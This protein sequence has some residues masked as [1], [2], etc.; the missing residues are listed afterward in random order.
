MKTFSLQERYSYP[1]RVIESIKNANAGIQ[2]L[3][4]VIL[5]LVILA[6]PGLSKAT[7]SFARQ[8][9]MSCTAC[10]YSFPE[11]TPFGRQF[12]LNAYTMTMMN[13]ID[14][15]QDSDKVTRLK[16]L[17]YLPLSAM[18]QTSFTNNAKTIEGTQNNS[19]AF[20][21]QISMFYA[22]QITPHIGSFIQMTYDGQV[23][24]MDN[25]EIRYA[26]Q[27]SLGTTSLLYGV[28][29]NNNPTVQDVWNTTPAW[30][31]P[32]A[33]SEAANSPAKA[34]LI[35]SLGMQV[36]GLGVYALFNNLLYGEFTLYRSSPQGAANPPD[37]TSV[38][39]VKGV[40]PYWRVAL[41]HV[42]GNNY[43]ELG[44]FGMNSNN[45]VSGISGP[46][47]KF[48]DLGF[49]LQYEN[50]LNTG[51]FV[52]HSSMIRETE[53]RNSSTTNFH[54]NSFK[55][56]GN[57]YLKNGL[58]ATLG[59]FNSSGTADADVVESSTNKPNSNG[60]IYQI[61]YLP[62]YN[63]KFSIQ[64]VTYSKFNGASSN[65]DGSGRSAADNNTLYLLAWF[66]F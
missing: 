7:P 2:I 21:Q 16:L 10:H 15:K 48:T 65:Y 18:L 58:G 1:L 33:S 41:Q 4:L 64:Y 38:M 66:N 5:L 20:P 39:T 19:I 59:Y 51:T 47:D 57:L 37:G 25:A 56:D 49:D 17:S 60:F 53:K 31:F 26:N 11:L 50:S 62:W 61:E 27:T 29:L 12:K 13:T 44:T 3:K 14:S 30:G 52:L 24:G 28:T 8:T 34:T 45:Y 46:L 43:A 22:G 6:H 35:E 23:F 54:F 32:T 40:A 36:A 55:I 42:W 63:T 9:G